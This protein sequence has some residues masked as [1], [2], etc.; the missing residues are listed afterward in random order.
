MAALIRSSYRRWQI[1]KHT[2]IPQCALKDFQTLKR[3]HLKAFVGSRRFSNL[4]MPMK[5]LN[6]RTPEDV[7]KCELFRVTEKADIPA[8]QL[9]QPKVFISV[10]VVKFSPTELE[11]LNKLN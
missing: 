1:R 11:H 10:E 3:G 6:K 7:R 4:R 9:P 2:A 8:P 5:N